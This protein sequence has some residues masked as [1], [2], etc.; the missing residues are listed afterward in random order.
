MEKTNNFS[1]FLWEARSQVIS[2]FAMSNVHKNN[3][4][5][6]LIECHMNT[7]IYKQKR[8]NI[9]YLLSY[10]LGKT[11]GSLQASYLAILSTCGYLFDSVH[12]VG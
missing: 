5:Q 9:V 3:C 11:P 6:R 8:D 4:F 2:I 7:I 10:K 1:H 12:F